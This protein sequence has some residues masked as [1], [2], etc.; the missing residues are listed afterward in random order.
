M[1]LNL[2]AYRLTA[3]FTQSISHAVS[4]GKFHPRRDEICRPL[5]EIL[6]FSERGRIYERARNREKF[7]A[8]FYAA[9]TYPQRVPKRSLFAQEVFHIRLRVAA[10]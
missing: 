1:N 9:F 8:L 4:H 2:T 10:Y 3:N 6:K 7:C 5:A